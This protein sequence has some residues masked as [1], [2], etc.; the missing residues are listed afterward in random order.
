M[1]NLPRFGHTIVHEAKL[2]G[3]FVPKGRGHLITRSPRIELVAIECPRH[4]A[5]KGQFILGVLLDYGG[6]LGEG[7]G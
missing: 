4:T 1:L 2:T 6:F 3:G 5:E 7:G